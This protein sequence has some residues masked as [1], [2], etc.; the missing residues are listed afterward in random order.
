V[1]FPK[2]PTEIRI[3]I[4]RFVISVPRIVEVIFNDYWQYKNTN[5]PPVISTCAESRYESLKAYYSTITGPEWIRCDLDVLYLKYLDFYDNKGFDRRRF[6]GSI[7]RWDP[8]DEDVS[9]ES[10]KWIGRPQSFEMV[11]ILAINREVLTQTWDDYECIIRYFFPS[12]KLLVVLVDDAIAIEYVWDIKSNDFEVYEGNWGEF[13]PYWEFIRGSTGP[14][15]IISI[16][17]MR[18]KEY[19]EIQMEKRFKREEEDYKDYIAPSICIM[20]YWLPPGVD[21]PECGRWP[22][23]WTGR[24][25]M[26]V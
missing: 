16:E 11:S 5:P 1:L 7:Q 17:N 20:G 22:D 3:K 24:V 10:N 2:L 18:Y 13:P 8:Q 15:T 4:W 6:Q 26:Q 9:T 19:I 12:L 21:I 14:F 23:D 25:R